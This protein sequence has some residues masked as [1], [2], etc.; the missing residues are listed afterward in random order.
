MIQS[1]PCVINERSKWIPINQKN[2]SATHITSN[3]INKN[4]SLKQ[5]FFDP[6]KSSPPNE[7][8]IKLHMRM[9]NMMRDEK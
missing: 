8:M 6:S 3:A 4:Y 1:V 2:L 9:T 5:N 7:F